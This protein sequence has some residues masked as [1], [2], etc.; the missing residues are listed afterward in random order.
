MTFKEIS[1]LNKSSIP[2][3][4]EAEYARLIKSY[5]VHKNKVLRAFITAFT[6]C[7]AALLLF[8]AIG[9]AS[10]VYT[11]YPAVFWAV[12]GVLGAA[13]A[14]CAACVGVNMYQF[15]KFLKKF[16]K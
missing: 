6:V 11:T 13:C 12:I 1:K 8:V 14:V 2:A 7:I 3:G 10:D 4:K 5:I 16:E 9:R 15:H